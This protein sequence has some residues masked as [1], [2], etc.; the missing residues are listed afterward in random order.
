MAPPQ[1]AARH[2]AED[3]ETFLLHRF[4]DEIP[5]NLGFCSDVCTECH[6]LHWKRERS[7]KSPLGQSASYT[8]CCRNGKVVL[9]LH[10][11]TFP[12]APPFLMSLLTEDTDRELFR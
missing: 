10:Y 8:M 11:F 9:P 4:R 1:I 7:T 6:A 3:H 5:H 12:T 2:F